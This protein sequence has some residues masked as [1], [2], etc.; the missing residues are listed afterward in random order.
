MIMLMKHN[1][2]KTNNISSQ[3]EIAWLKMILINMLL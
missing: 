2:K 1:A 3:L